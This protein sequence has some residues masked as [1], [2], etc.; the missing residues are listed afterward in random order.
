MSAE[1]R[2]GSLRDSHKVELSGTV[3]SRELMAK[4]PSSHRNSN[5][6]R[7]LGRKSSTNL[8]LQRTAV[9]RNISLHDPHAERYSSAQAP[10]RG[11]SQSKVIEQHHIPR[12]PSQFGQS[13]SSPK[14][15]QLDRRSSTHQES[16]RNRGT[17]IGR[18]GAVD[19]KIGRINDQ[20]RRA[21]D[22]NHR[23]EEDDRTKSTMDSQIRRQTESS[24]EEQTR[25]DDFVRHPRSKSPMALDLTASYRLRDHSPV[26]KTA[27][28]LTRFN[29]SVLSNVYIAL[30]N[31]FHSASGIGLSYTPR[32]LQGQHAADDRC[33]GPPAPTPS[34]LNPLRRHL[35]L[36]RSAIVAPSIH[37][38]SND[39]PIGSTI[40]GKLTNGNDVI[41]PV[42][43]SAMSISSGSTPSPSFTSFS[44]RNPH[45]QKRNTCIM[46]KRPEV[47][48]ID[49]LVRCNRC[50][51]RYHT[52]C[53]N[54]KITCTKGDM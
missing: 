13:G 20:I 49:L 6:S 9:P 40:P 29:G 1:I 28:L 18:L 53:H 33:R 27:Q 46:C 2:S 22:D 41:T 35:S 8:R 16:F 50:H 48:I 19:L 52:S 17:D 47:P 45:H 30:A 38:A 26:T 11:L 23:V 15:L 51:C 4:Q 5:H 37:I 24:A 43:T 44:G 12:E 3:N 42:S 54:P 34:A 14:R 39:G 25:C 36:P 7:E 10:F 21:R 31:S 32:N